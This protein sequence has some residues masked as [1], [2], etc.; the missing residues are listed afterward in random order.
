MYVHEENLDMPEI[1]HGQNSSTPRYI[2]WCT[3]GMEVVVMDHY[4]SWQRTDQ[5]S[6]TMDHREYIR[7]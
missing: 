7:S 5:Q 1:G 3:G 6:T 4:G 2:D